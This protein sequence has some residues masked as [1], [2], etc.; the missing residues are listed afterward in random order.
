MSLHQAHSLAQSARGAVAESDTCCL[1]QEYVA[2][3]GEM[4]RIGAH[5]G[6]NQQVSTR[7]GGCPD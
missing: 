2:Q 6:I 3:L 5:R 7:Q 1:P 4:L